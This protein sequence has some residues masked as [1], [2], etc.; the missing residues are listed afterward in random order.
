MSK[1]LEL[2]R[3]SI[4]KKFNKWTFIA[5]EYKEK[6]NNKLYSLIFMVCRCCCGEI[7]R[8]PAY[9]CFGKTVS[10]SLPYECNLCSR[11]NKDLHWRTE[12]EMEE[13]FF[14]EHIKASPMENELIVAGYTQFY[15]KFYRD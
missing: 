9:T 6:S 5:Y 8:Y 10:K 7:R 3:K 14:N 11:K 2:A 15:K 12:R 4:G 1:F 13:D